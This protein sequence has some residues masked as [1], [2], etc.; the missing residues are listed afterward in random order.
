VICQIGVRKQ[1]DFM[2]KQ[3]LMKL[4][5]QIAPNMKPNNQ[6]NNKPKPRDAGYQKKPVVV[7]PRKQNDR[8]SFNSSASNLFPDQNKTSSM[9]ATT[10]QFCSVYTDPFLQTEASLPVLP[11]LAHQC[12]ISK[13]GG[14]GVTNTSGIGSVTI[15]PINMITNDLVSAVYSS[16]SATVASTFL[17][18]GASGAST[19][20]SNSPYAST[21]FDL[22]LPNLLQAR[23]VAVGLRVKYTGSVFNAA[24]NIYTIEL[25]PKRT[26]ADLV[27][28]N[29]A[30]VKTQ[31]NYKEYQFSNGV[32]HSITRHI[33]SRADYDYQGWDTTLSRFQYSQ[34]FS[35]SVGSAQSLDGSWSIGAIFSTTPNT[36][37]EFEVSCHFE[38][39]GANL[40]SRE[41]IYSDRAIVENIVSVYKKLR[42][43]DTIT[44]DHSV[45]VPPNSK[46]GWVEKLKTFAGLAVPMIP[47]ILQML[48]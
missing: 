20:S 24:G 13:T 40:P 12:V 2:N 30:F 22:T 9:M 10:A 46:G 26:Y 47:K 6:N 48:L 33:Q 36:T 1:S 34:N 37:F 17:S 21:A 43:A 39:V 25:E 19:A 8:K 15:V 5:E 14:V 32:W 3:Q 31:P 16:N 41:L 23:L 7:K 11:L 4:V 44:P 29:I 35:P 28:E 45:S 27:N 42:Y 38:V 18:A